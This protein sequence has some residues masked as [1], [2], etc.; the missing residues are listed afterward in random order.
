MS[1]GEILRHPLSRQEKLGVRTIGMASSAAQSPNDW[2]A[3]QRV[4]RVFL[5]SRQRLLLFSYLAHARQRRLTRKLHTRF[6]QI[7]EYVFGSS[8]MV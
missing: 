2:I 4:S 8:S 3:W 1:D 7:E 6:N 5:I